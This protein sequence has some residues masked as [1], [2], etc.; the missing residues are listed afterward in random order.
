[1]ITG[2]GQR[3]TGG[4]QVF[5]TAAF[6]RLAFLR[7]GRSR[8]SRLLGRSTGDDRRAHAGIIGPVEDAPVAA[9]TMSLDGLVVELSV[10]HAHGWVRDLT[11][12]SRR[13]DCRAIVTTSGEIVGEGRADQ[14]K[15]GLSAGGIGDGTYS[16]W[17]TFR[18]ILTEEELGQTRIKVAGTDGE[19]GFAGNAGREFMPVLHVAM[20][21][22]DNCNLRCPFCLY[23]YGSTRAT[24]F[25]SAETLGAALRYLEY[26]QDGEFWFSCLHEP[27]LHPDLVAYVDSV[28][29]EYRRKLFFTTNLAKRMPESYFGWLASNGMHHI[30]VSIESMRP[31]IYE[32]MR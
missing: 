31:E 14:F 24:H 23:D 29:P 20:D 32:K 6:R 21:I 10:R 16:F 5:S 22:V 12:P 25:M 4:G 30:N 28:P 1:M 7:R 13:L 19:I 17:F 18:R 26:T 3:R 11:D 15:H 8:L 27:T 2:Y 9:S